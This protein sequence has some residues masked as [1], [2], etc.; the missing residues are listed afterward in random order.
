MIVVSSDKT[1]FPPGTV[2]RDFIEFVDFAPTIY[3]AAGLDVTQPEYSHL[4]GRPLQKVVA[5]SAKKLAYV[6]GEMNHV[7]GPRAYLRSN[8][9]AFSMRTREK[10][11]KPGD[12]YG[13][14]PGENIRW[15]LE[16]SPNEVEIAFFDLRIDPME[17][18]NLAG[19]ARYEKLVNF[20]RQ[21][22][23]NIVLGD[24]RLEVDWKQENTF[25]IS[26]FSLGADDKQ[27]DIPA[28]II[29]QL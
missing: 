1:A 13:H 18:H 24:R 22:L 16:A 26:D 9:F 29:P 21:K 3:T 5:G 2:N 17:R 6:L 15:A 11:G 27:L 10:N 28:D 23:G 25:H 14:A 20:F 19:D 12:K 8:D 7:Y 4:D